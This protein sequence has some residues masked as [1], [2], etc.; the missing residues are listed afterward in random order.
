[1]AGARERIALFDNIKGLLIILVVAAHF[2]HPVHN[3]N[4]ALSALFDITY[5]FHMPLFV[6]SPGSSQRAPIA[7]GTS[8]GTGSS[9]SRFWASPTRQRCS[10]STG[11]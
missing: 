5:L 6:S 11:C 8:T 1:M 4:E 9:P 10:R 2:M 3:D 7:T